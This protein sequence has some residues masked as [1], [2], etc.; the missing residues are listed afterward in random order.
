MGHLSGKELY[1]DLGEKIDGL[2]MRA[3]QNER[4]YAIL[5]EL[6]SEE[7]ADVVIKMPYGL[8]N[9][10]RVARATGYDRTKLQHILESLTSKGLVLDIWSKGEYHYMPSP[11]VVGIF[12]FTMMRTDA[13]HDAKMFAHLMHDYMQ[14]DDSFYA[15][16]LEQGEQVSIMRS[17]P[18]GD[19][20]RPEEYVEVLDYEKAA[21]LV[22][23][24]DRYAVSLCSCRHKGYHLGTK[25]CDVPLESCTSFGM[26]ANY[27]IRHNLGREVSKEEMLETLELSKEHGLVLNADNVRHRIMFICQCCKCC[28][29]TLQGISTFGFPNTVVTSSFIAEV[30]DENCNGCGLCEKACPINAIEM[31]PLENPETKKKKQPVIDTG[32]CLGC[33]VCAL[34]CKFEGVHLTKRKQRVIHPETTF[35]RIILQSLERGT[36]QNQLF[37]D[38][39]S[40]SHRFMRAFLGAFF[41]LSPVRK[42]LMSDMLRSTFLKSVKVGAYFQGKGWQTEL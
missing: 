18:H 42:A 7:E 24:A 29:A 17:L 36:V 34:S 16:N 40:I 22:E 38:P 26:A 10:E 35:E 2:M 30:D 5:R 21:A 11:M 33:G 6:Y 3:P 32:I 37:D 8:A 28:C 27:I 31:V 12:E 4:F 13:G 23:E 20:I 9:L 14:G 25:E 41:R 15:K 19:A 1:R 39:V